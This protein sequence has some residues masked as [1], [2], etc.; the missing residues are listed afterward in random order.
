[1]VLFSNA[2]NARC[3]SAHGQNIVLSNPFQ[4]D[5]KIPVQ[6]SNFDALQMGA[7][8][9]AHDFMKLNKNHIYQ[10]KYTTKSIPS[11]GTTI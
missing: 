8:L 11:P 2:N 10:Y 3:D 1:M 6:P 9:G 7:L 4:M 5:V